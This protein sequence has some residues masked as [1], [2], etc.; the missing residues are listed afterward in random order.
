MTGN[1]P[2]FY[3]VGGYI[4]RALEDAL[5]REETIYFVRVEIDSDG[6]YRTGH[7]FH[8]GDFR[9]H[10]ID[11]VRELFAD[12]DDRNEHTYPDSWETAFKDDDCLTHE[13]TVGD[14]TFR[15]GAYSFTRVAE[16][17]KDSEIKER[18]F[19]DNGNQLFSR[20]EFLVEFRGAYADSVINHNMFRE[21]HSTMQPASSERLVQILDEAGRLHDRYVSIPKGSLLVTKDWVFPYVLGRKEHDGEL[22][23]RS[24]KYCSY[25]EGSGPRFPTINKEVWICGVEEKP[26]LG[27]VLSGQFSNAMGFYN[28]TVVVPKDEER[29]YVRQAIASMGDFDSIGFQNVPVA[30]FG[31]EATRP[32][33]WNPEQRELVR[34]INE[35]LEIR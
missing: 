25:F 32:V 11:A 30:L 17:A 29:D 20:A 21:G 7:F 2:D 8:S 4:G 9:D 13:V 16:I 3:K 27:L 12:T 10:T 35:S 1:L 24:S 23:W 14:Y 19:D 22:R 15:I 6:L 26:T 31:E 34:V 5:Q 18:R 33:Y 28:A